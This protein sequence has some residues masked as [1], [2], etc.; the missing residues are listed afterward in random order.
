MTDLTPKTLARTRNRPPMPAMPSA[1]P[2]LYP[3]L[4]TSPT[5]A[6]KAKSKATAKSKAKKAPKA[7]AK[8]TRKP[9]AVLGERI[10]TKRMRGR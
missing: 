9:P 6:A 7:K 10:F 5:S 2:L 3:V 1:S 4:P 8:A